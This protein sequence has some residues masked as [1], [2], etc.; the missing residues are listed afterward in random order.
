[1]LASL[2][3]DS[4]DTLHLIGAGALLYFGVKFAICLGTWIY[5]TLLMSSIDL[6]KYKGQ[7]AVVTG[8]TDGIGKAFAFALA[9]KGVNV[10]LISRTQAK[11]DAVAAEIRE[12]HGVEVKTIPVDFV[13]DDAVNYKIKIASEIEGLEVS[14]ACLYV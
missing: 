8:A 11:L 10:V 13:Q 12:K 3:F 2:N 4:G 14:T 6:A 1:M 5:E 7:W 9:K